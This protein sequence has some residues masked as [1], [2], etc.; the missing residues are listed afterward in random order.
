LEGNGLS[1]GKST[2]LAVVD[3]PAMDMVA[4]PGLCVPHVCGA[5]Q[6][7]DAGRLADM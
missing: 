2:V 7:F 4:N 6:R 3:M 5:A 1:C